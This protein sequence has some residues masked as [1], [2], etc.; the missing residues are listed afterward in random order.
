MKDFDLTENQFIDMSIL[1]GCDYS[2]KIQGI[3][4]VKAFKFIKEFHS[5]ENVLDH[6]K[7]E[8][9]K[10]DKIRYVIPSENDFTYEEA[11]QLFKKPLVTDDFELKWDKNFDEVALKKFLC[12]GKGF[13]EERVEKAIG[14]L[15][16]VKPAQPRL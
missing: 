4:P 11:R 16:T 7:Y 13:N 3:G 9:Q 2:P 8:N 12:V 10:D 1:C 15:K 6:C 5:I 14:K